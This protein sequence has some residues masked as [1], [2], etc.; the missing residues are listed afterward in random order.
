MRITSGIARGHK[1]K[2]PKVADLRPSQD[3]V[4]QAIFNVLEASTKNE[5]EKSKIQGAH[6]LDLYAGTGALGIEALSRGAQRANFVDHKQRVC[7]VIEQ[8]LNHSRLM[9]KAKVICRDAERFVDETPPQK[10]DFIFLDPP[11]L[12]RPLPVLMQLTDILK[13]H[14]TI[15]YLHD[16]RII[17]DQNSR[18]LLGERLKVLDTRKYG[19]TVV[20]FLGKKP[21]RKV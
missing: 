10:Y 15:I 4:R 14:G 19:R 9:G 3:I 8:N 13:N 5:E 6:V 20:T 11:Y 16:Q 1:L 21:Q 7:E 18:K 12:L 2:V 17:L